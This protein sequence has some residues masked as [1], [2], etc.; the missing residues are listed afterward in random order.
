MRSRP[1]QLAS[2]AF[3]AVLLATCMLLP[4]LTAHIFLYHHGG[5]HWSGGSQGLDLPF[6]LVRVQHRASD[7][8][9]LLLLLLLLF[10]R[11]P[12]SESCGTLNMAADKLDAVL[13]GL[14]RRLL[15]LL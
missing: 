1:V 14:V 4:T 9:L 13:R 3:M 5:M 7:Y 6:V 2:T 11:R 10:L 12:V 8:P 15:L